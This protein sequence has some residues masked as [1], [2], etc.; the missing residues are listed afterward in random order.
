MLGGI[1]HWCCVVV[2]QL[3][4]TE[5]V[6]IYICRAGLG[7]G[8]FVS[9]RTITLFYSTTKENNN[10]LPYSN[11]L[12]RH[13]S[14]TRPNQEQTIDLTIDIFFQDGCCCILCMF[15]SFS[16]I[17]P[18]SGKG[19]NV[20]QQIQSVF[21]A[22]GACLMGIVNTIGAVCKA[23]IDGVV[24]LFD[25]IISCLTCGYCGRRRRGTTRTRRSRI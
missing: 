4:G 21:H 11:H 20:R 17:L 15:P 22:I 2:N 12:L 23:I 18:L 25:V 10:T 1:H 19:S 24:T 13:H 8:L 5:D 3:F 7:S 14:V 9:A 16:F 6:Y